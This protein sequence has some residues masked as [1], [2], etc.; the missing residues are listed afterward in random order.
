M[1]KRTSL[2][3]SIS[4]RLQLGLLRDPFKGL[5]CND[6]NGDTYLSSLSECNQEMVNEQ[7]TL[8][9]QLCDKHYRKSSALSIIKDMETKSD[10][11]SSA[12]VPPQKKPSQTT[13]S[14]TGSASKDNVRKSIKVVNDDPLSIIAT[15]EEERVKIDK[16]TLMERKK[17]LAMASRLQKKQ[18][19]SS[20][21]LN[22]SSQYK[23]SSQSIGNVEGPLKGSKTRWNEFY[24]SKEDMDIIKKDLDRLP[25]NHNHYFHQLKERMWSHQHCNSAVDDNSMTKSRE[26]RAMML[27]EILFVYAREHSIGYRQGMHEILSFAMMAIE[28][29]LI[30]KE[31]TDVPIVNKCPFLLNN[32][33]INH[34][35]YTIFDAIMTRL[36]LAFGHYEEKSHPTIRP[37]RIGSATVRIIREWHGDDLLADFLM[38]LDVPPR[39]LLCKMDTAH[40]Q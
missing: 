17:N 5:E 33:K 22:D 32:T 16:M 37:E 26:E 8:Y 1:A 9:D 23:T 27:A 19:S 35:T 18:I 38:D 3:R 7:R 20:T 40:V 14:G 12:K 25:L 4:W 34:D 28:K 39:A 15:M 36:S 10:T 11:E 24:S 2:P 13:S 30:A 6:Y 31:W 29:D 21:E